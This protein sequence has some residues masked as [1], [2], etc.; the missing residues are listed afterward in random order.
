MNTETRNDRTWIW[1]LVLFT[2]GSFIEALLYGH[3][4]AFTPLYLPKLGISLAEVPT[5]TGIIAAVAGIPG[6]LFLPFWGALADKY[7]RKP[8]IIRSFVVDVVMAL[9]VALAGNVWIFLVCRALSGLALGNS[10]LMMTTLAERSPNNRRG[11]AFAIMNTAA[12][13]GVFAGPL[14]GGAIMDRWGFPALMGVDAVLLAVVV[15]SLSLAYR[16]AFKGQDDRPLLE[17]AAESVNIIWRSPSLRALFP[18]LF[19]LFAGWMLAMTYVPIAISD[20]YSGPNK[21][22]MVGVVLGA[23][24]FVALLLGPL[25]GALGDRFG[26][27]RVLFIGALL[28]I[29]LWPLLALLPGLVAFGAVYALVNGIGSGV[30]AISFSVLSNSTTASVRGRVMSFSFLPAN[31]GSMIGPALGALVTRQS[32][33]AAFPTAALLTACGLVM[34]VYAYRKQA[35]GVR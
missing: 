25:F 14:F 3:L 28:Q 16:E 29:L 22:S 4:G 35:V 2:F 9:A 15:L 21:A 27:W 20:L 33:F 1:L 31:I 11:L 18:A 32:V 5:W 10:G 30:F 26:L 24:G 7:A 12:P 17:M 23:G 13:I 34:M 6:L 19:M 8:I